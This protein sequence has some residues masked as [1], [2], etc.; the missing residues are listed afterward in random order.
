[1]DTMKKRLIVAGVLGISLF[2]VVYFWVHKSSRLP[3]PAEQQSRATSD[4]EIAELAYVAAPHVSMRINGTH[5]PVVGLG[6]PLIV[7]L[8]ASNQGAING[9]L[10][11]RARKERWAALQGKLNS[12]PVQKEEVAALAT[13][14][15]R[16][17]PI[18]VVQLGGEAVGWEQ[19]VRFVRRLPDGK[20]EPLP[21][22]LERIG[23]SPDKKLVLD[24]E[25]NVQIDFGLAPAAAATIEPG[26]Y[27]IVGILEVPGS[28]T[29]P[30]DQWRG[31]SETEPVMLKVLP[32]QPPPSAAEKLRSELDS[33]NY[34]LATNQPDLALKHAEAAL[35]ASPAD[36]DAQIAV[37]DSKAQSDPQD[38]LAAYQ[39]ALKEIHSQSPIPSEP[40]FLL[41]DKIYKLR[42]KLEGNPH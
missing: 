15:Q 8:R 41:S 12:G 33:V 13:R 40:P 37:G 3:I 24:A 36:V 19:F 39:T 38:A 11:N 16:E 25:T 14:L 5:E 7:S 34:F 2:A 42:E 27:E 23:A 21:W 9:Q 30:A 35:A 10:I 6:T 17:A 20:E 31:R 28:P 4:S 26:D 22:K 32:Q 18:K 29:V 1:M